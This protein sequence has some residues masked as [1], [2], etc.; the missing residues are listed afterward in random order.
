M[1]AHTQMNCG[2]LWIETWIQICELL[3]VEI[4]RV[5]IFIIS[6]RECQENNAHYPEY[7]DY[8]A[9]IQKYSNNCEP[10]KPK[11]GPYSEDEVH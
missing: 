6:S 5:S 11:Y 2:I 9:S 7:A 1:N 10:C 4:Q 8:M 3:I